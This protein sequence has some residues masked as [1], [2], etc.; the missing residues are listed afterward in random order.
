MAARVSARLTPQ[1]GRR[2]GLTVGGAFLTFAAI[3]WWRESPT[4]M[5]I[6]A[7]LGG[8]LGFAALV[9][10]AH[11]GPV[12]RAWMALA[13]AISRVTTPIVMAVMYFVV[14]TPSAIARRAFGGNPLV[15]APAPIGFWKPRPAGSRRSKSMERQF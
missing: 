5:S 2:F 3:A 4:A 8:T 12:E 7:A 6:F 15:H 13:H 1:Q 9:A 11:L 10:P 14:I